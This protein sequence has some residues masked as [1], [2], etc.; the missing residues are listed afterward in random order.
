MGMAFLAAGRVLASL[1]CWGR[2]GSDTDE[3]NEVAGHAFAF[4][5]TT[6]HEALEIGGR[7]F[8]AEEDATLVGFFKAAEGGI[9]TH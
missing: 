2:S 1:V 5:G 7:V 3:V 6:F 9:L 4:R 8:A